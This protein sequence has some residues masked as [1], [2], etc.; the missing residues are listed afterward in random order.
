M[1]LVF[2]AKKIFE[3]SI[4]MENSKNAKHAEFVSI[5]KTYIDTRRAAFKEITKLDTTAADYKAQK[6]AKL[7]EVKAALLTRKAAVKAL[8][9]RK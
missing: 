7:A 9:Q 6:A 1:V 4:K 3:L 8:R 5:S 2:A